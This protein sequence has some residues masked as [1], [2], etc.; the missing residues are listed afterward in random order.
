MNP[1]EAFRPI[2]WR[3]NFLKDF[4]LIWSIYFPYDKFDPISACLL[5]KCTR[6]FKCPIA[7]LLNINARD[8]G[9]FA[10]PFFRQLFDWFC[11]INCNAICF[12][13]HPHTCTAS[14]CIWILRKVLFKRLWLRDSWL[15]L[16]QESWLPSSQ[17]GYSP[18]LFWASLAHIGFAP[19][20]RFLKDQPM[21]WVHFGSWIDG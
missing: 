17:E 14:I 11:L 1:L 21:K 7:F 8:F 13:L 10:G 19:Q 18:L 16:C 2:I 9:V 3:R 6:G 20:W 5:N 4:G 12:L 15:G